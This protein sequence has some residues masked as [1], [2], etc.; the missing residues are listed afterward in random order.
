MEFRVIIEFDG[1][2][3]C[4]E[5]TGRGFRPEKLRAGETEFTVEARDRSIAIRKAS[6]LWWER[7]MEEQ[8]MAKKKKKKKRKKRMSGY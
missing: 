7:F 6:A 8:E 2:F 4:C 1:I 5:E 3:R